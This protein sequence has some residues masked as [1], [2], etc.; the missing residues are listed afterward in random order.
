VARVRRRAQRRL[1][2]DAGRTG[3]R[4]ELVVSGAEPAAFAFAPDG[5]MFYTE[6]TSGETMSVQLAPVAVTPEQQQLAPVIAAR[7]ELARRTDRQ[8][9]NIA[10]QGIR[11]PPQ[12]P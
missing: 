12:I 10:V 6:R 7:K 5:R 4:G 2:E 1:L 11:V 8:E 3:P 9:G